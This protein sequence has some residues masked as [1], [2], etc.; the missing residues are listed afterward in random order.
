[1]RLATVG[2][3]VITHH[4][5]DALKQEPYFEL[6]YVYSR[7]EEKG[8]D[9]AKQYEVP[10]ISDW[11]TLL[12]QKDIDV[13]YLA[14]PNDV[15][16]S[17]CIEALRAHKH[18]I[19]EK[20]FVSNMREFNEV[21]RVVQETKHFCF[22]AMTLMHLPNLQVIKD[23]LSEIEPIKLVNSAM[24]QYSSRFDLLAQGTIPNIFDLDHSGGALMDLGVYPLGLCIA[25]FGKPESIHY[26]CNKY[27]N[28]IDLSGILTLKYPDNVAACVIGKDSRGQNF[29]YIS[30]EKGAIVIPEQ[31]S[32][33]V[34][35]QVVTPQETRN[36]GV[37]QAQNAMV[38]EIK[39]FASILKNND[40]NTYQSHVNNTEILMTCLDD[41][42]KQTKIVFKA[43]Q[44][45]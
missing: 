36:V 6:A 44:L 19:C 15:H 34:N 33:L 35:V 26:D 12:N 30:G 38:D 21:M 3:S 9:F 28:G 16:F 24:V 10:V 40:W 41:A 5:L 2:T 20:P 25:L 11:N 14:T 39:A 42:R 17:Q 45:V 37:E 8:L 43:D 13:L 32:R 27:V 18:V 23:H 29:T 4:F 31:P 7:N 1:M 22:D